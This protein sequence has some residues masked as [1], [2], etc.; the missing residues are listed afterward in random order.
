MIER[1]LKSQISHLKFQIW[2]SEPC[3]S[4][5][6]AGFCF[7]SFAFSNK[8]VNAKNAKEEGHSPS[9]TNHE[10]RTTATFVKHQRPARPSC[11]H[12]ETTR[13][14]EAQTAQ[15][16]TNRTKC[17]KVH[18]LH[19]LHRSIRRRGGNTADRECIWIVLTARGSPCYPRGSCLFWH[20]MPLLTAQVSVFQAERK[21]L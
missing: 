19:D 4:A 10:Q 3:I 15:I 2:D 18:D 8:N 17:I 12:S 1:G 6:F 7:A 20:G 14:F 13:P 16:D 9:T 11:H 5:I 21:A